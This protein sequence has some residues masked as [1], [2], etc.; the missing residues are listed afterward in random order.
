MTLAATMQAAV[1]LRVPVVIGS[2]LDMTI[3]RLFIEG[4]IALWITS[5]PFN[6]G[7]RSH[8]VRKIL[9]SRQL[10]SVNE[11]LCAGTSTRRNQPG[12]ANDG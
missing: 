2:I 4:Q 1:I 6:T 11:Y 5:T 3:I 9:I 10:K 8:Q 12:V 7:I